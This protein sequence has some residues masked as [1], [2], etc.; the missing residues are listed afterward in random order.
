MV[1][2]QFALKVAALL[3]IQAGTE[4][5]RAV[6]PHRGQRSYVR[7]AIGSDRRDPEAV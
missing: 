5:Q 4:V 7:P 2:M 3:L 1:R 6:E